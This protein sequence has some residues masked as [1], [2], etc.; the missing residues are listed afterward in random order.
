MKDSGETTR[1][2]KKKIE[3]FLLDD[4]FIS[5]VPEMI[6]MGERRVVNPLFSFFCHNNELIK[7][8]SIT[9]MGL[10]VDHLAAHDPESARVVMRRLMWSLNDESGGIGWGAPEAMGE[11]MAVNALMAAEYCRMLISY[12]NPGGNFLEH[13]ILQRGALWG[14]GR[15]AHTRPHLMKDGAG[16]LNRFMMSTDALKRGLAAWA[17]RPLK[18]GGNRVYLEN[19]LGD[20]SEI[21]I[22]MDGTMKRFTVGGLAEEAFRSF[23]SPIP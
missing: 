10:V 7:W 2:L 9:V 8:R 1:Q 17:D 3:L 23:K 11:I 14:F 13:E 5:M 16:F 4:D 22:Y 19:L 15:L 21:E 20:D 12:I 6:E 18:D